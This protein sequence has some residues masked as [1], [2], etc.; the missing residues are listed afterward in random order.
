M[1]GE[2]RSDTESGIY[3]ELRPLFYPRSVAV[4]G[5][6]QDAWKPGSTMLRALVRFGFPGRLYPVGSRG[7]EMMELEVRPSIAALP[8]VVDLAFLFV[9]APALPS[10]VR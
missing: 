5:V 4:V 1:S 7:G 8:E 6:S 10:V 9:P 2:S 3:E